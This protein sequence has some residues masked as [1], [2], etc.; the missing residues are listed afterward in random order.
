MSGDVPYDAL[1]TLIAFMVGVPA[2]VLQTLPPEVR[3]V[4]SKR[5]GR[6]LADLTV[7]VLFAIAISL[8]G[9]FAPRLSP[10]STRI[11]WTGILGIIVLT[12]VYTVF[13]ILSRYGRRLAI[14]RALEREVGR[15]VPKTGRLIEASL[16]DLVDL[17][18]QSQ[19]GREKELVLESL[20]NLSARVYRHPRYGGDGFEDLVLGVMDIVL[21]APLRGNGQNVASATRILQGI[22]LRYEAR[23]EE[24]PKLLR[25][26]DLIVALRA[27]SKLGR[28]A[29]VMDQEAIPL[30]VVQAV[31]TSRVEGTAIFVSQALFEVGVAAIQADQM[32][33]AM[34]AIEKL[35]SLVELQKPARGE[36]VA[37]TLGLLA[38]FHASGNTGARFARVRLSRLEVCLSESLPAALE[39]ASAHCARTTHFRTA[40]RIEQLSRALFDRPRGER[41]WGAV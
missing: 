21:G 29:C 38:H 20:Q 9:I 11:T 18:R 24:Q 28:V 27:L 40:D 7:P 14:V 4:V 36:L 2:V 17:G 16:D 31:S 33:V 35:L 30:A 10:G 32:L 12:T 26:A 13:R 22:V 1:T 25:H 15:K 34:S 41:S 23:A 5:W 8:L 39:A 3:R 19:P 6:L 37:D